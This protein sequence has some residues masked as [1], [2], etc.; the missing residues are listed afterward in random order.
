MWILHFPASHQCT[1]PCHMRLSTKSVMVA[2][3]FGLIVYALIDG[4]RYQSGWGITMASCSLFALFAIVRL[5][6]KLSRLEA[7]EESQ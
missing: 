4:I 6:Q 3:A 5:T 2:L 1:K 7:D